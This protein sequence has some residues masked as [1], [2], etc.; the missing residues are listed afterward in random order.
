MSIAPGCQESTSATLLPYS[1]RTAALSLTVPGDQETTAVYAGD[2]SRDFYRI[3][4]WRVHG[5]NIAAVFANNWSCGLLTEPGGCEHT[6][7]HH[8]G[9]LRGEQKP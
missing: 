6:R 7:R 4:W 5:G 2:N 8:C 9:R 1:R 3:R